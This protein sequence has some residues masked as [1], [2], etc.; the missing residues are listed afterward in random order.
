MWGNRP[1]GYVGEASTKEG[2]R[3]IQRHE[4]R[5]TKIKR[6]YDT[7]SV[8]KN[9]YTTQEGRTLRTEGHSRHE[10]SELLLSRKSARKSHKRLPRRSGTL[11]YQ[12]AQ[13]VLHSGSGSKRR[14]KRSRSLSKR[15]SSRTGR[16]LSSRTTTP[17]KSRTSYVTIPGQ[18]DAWD[19]LYSVWGK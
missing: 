2:A 8:R 3:D 18:M 6:E 9:P 12:S 7:R 16:S 19:Y 5:T 11:T 1:A 17:V 10:A 14:S 15:R 4:R 13:V